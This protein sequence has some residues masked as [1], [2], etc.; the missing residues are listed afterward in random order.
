MDCSPT[1]FSVHGFPRQEY[2][3]GLPFATPGDLPNLGIKP[4]SPALAGR[5]L[6]TEPPGN[7]HNINNGDFFH[8]LASCLCVY[9]K[10]QR[11]NLSTFFRR[12]TISDAGKVN[13]GP[14]TLRVTQAC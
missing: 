2:W 4:T 1:G 7:P 13:K 14:L 5:N 3:S 8:Y 10:S 9:P 11:K 12:P 6:T